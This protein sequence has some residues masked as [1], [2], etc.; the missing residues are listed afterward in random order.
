MRVAALVLAGCLLAAGCSGA[1]EA[2]P[3]PAPAPASEKG[4]PSPSAS[5]TADVRVPEGVELTRPGSDLRF[6]ESAVVVAEPD[7]GPSTVLELRVV[8]AR[9]APLSDF[10]DFRLDEAYTKRASYYYVEATIENVG[11]AGLGGAPVPLWGVDGDNTLLPPVTFTT[12]F[13]RCPSVALP[14]PFVPGDSVRSCLVYLA[15]NR[16]V[17]ESLSF[18]PDQ[19]FDPIEWTGRVDPVRQQ[20]PGTRDDGQKPRQRSGDR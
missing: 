17:L 18:R 6:G 4:S 20:R 12:D 11:E 3:A 1:D 19:A 9:R 15:P 8:G 2:D 13:P 7:R 5:P 16:G 10:S 14:D